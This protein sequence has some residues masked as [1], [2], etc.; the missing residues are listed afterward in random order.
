MLCDRPSREGMRQSLEVG[1]SRYRLPM[2]PEGGKFG[3]GFG[4]GPVPSWPQ[5]QRVG[6]FG[7]GEL[8]LSWLRRLTACVPLLAVKLNCVRDLLL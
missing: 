2:C 5:L 8:G 4:V 7:G 1:C 6:C 3:I